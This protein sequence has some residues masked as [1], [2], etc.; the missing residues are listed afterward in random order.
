M[1]KWQYQMLQDQ[2]TRKAKNNPCGKSGSFK[3]EEGYKE[4]ILAAKSIL[5]DFY[6]RYCE[7]EDQL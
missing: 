7:K 1:E 5:S 2:L 6:H 3:R 4:G